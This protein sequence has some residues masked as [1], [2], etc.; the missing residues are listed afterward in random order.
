MADPKAS[1]T[2]GYSKNCGNQVCTCQASTHTSYCSEQCE[3]SP[4]P[5]PCAVA[6]CYRSLREGREFQGGLWMACLLFKPHYGLLLGLLLIW[7]RRWRAVAGVAVGGGIVIGGSIVVPGLPALLSYPTS[8]IEMAKFR[9][10]VDDYLHMIN[11][12]SL[13]LTFRPGVNDLKGMLLTQFL[14]VITVLFT[15]LAWRGPWAPRDV[16]FPSQFTLLLL[17][18]LL[19]N[20]HSFNYGAAIL[21]VPIA[22]VMAEGRPNRVTRLAVIAGVILPT[23]FFTLVKFLD[24]PVASRILTFSLL[25]C[26]GGLLVELWRWNWTMAE[27]E[28][29][30]IY[31]GE[32]S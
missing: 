18:T 20:H 31:A 17:A 27:V 1:P 6:E 2:V 8:F 3:H 23:L 26:Y 12:R 24:V 15:A 25:T 7:K 10:N 4:P 13:V 16:R 32:R 5:V 29:Q 11:W 28:R 22:S 19:A 9:Q 21:A 14:G 30:T